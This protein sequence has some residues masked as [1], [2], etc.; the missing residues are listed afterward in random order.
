[1]ITAICPKCHCSADHCLFS[2]LKCADLEQLFREAHSHSRL[3]RNQKHRNQ[4]RYLRRSSELRSPSLAVPRRGIEFCRELRL[5]AAGRILELSFSSGH[6]AEH[7][8]HLLGT[9]DQ[10]P[11]QKHDQYFCTKTHGFTL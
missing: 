5:Y 4:Y 1:M 2:E 3:T 11:E 6:V 7:G 10:E 8:V 9:Q